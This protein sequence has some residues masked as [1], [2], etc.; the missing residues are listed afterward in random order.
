MVNFKNNTGLNLS[1]LESIFNALP[2]CPSFVKDN[3]HVY[4]LVNEAMLRFCG[5][6]HAHEMIGKSSADFFPRAIAREYETMER[7]IMRTGIPVS[8]HLELSKL[9]DGRRYWL[10]F[11]QIPIMDENGLA[12][13]IVSTASQMPSEGKK[14]KILT[15]LKKVVEAIQQNYEKPLD[16]AC[17]ARLAGTSKSQVGRDFHN[18]FGQSPQK[19]LNKVRMAHAIEMLEQDLTVADIAYA[20][21]YADHSAFTRRF[22]ET[23]GLSPVQ[24]RKINS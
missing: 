4:L 18:L 20:S 12:V 14:G 21:G 16:L 9:S 24:Y 13:G 11:S 7:H 10:L 23:Y 15:R 2:D 6:K 17:L 8:D 22:R 3:N 19:Y 1:L 5:V